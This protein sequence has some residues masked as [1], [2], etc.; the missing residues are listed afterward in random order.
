METTTSLEEKIQQLPPELQKEV[1]QIVQSLW[2]KSQHTKRQ[3]PKFEWA[4]ALKHLRDQYTSVE[5]QH[6]I[7]QE[8]MKQP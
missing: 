6:E 2:E 7:L 3:K 4:G 8:R 5:L 1:E